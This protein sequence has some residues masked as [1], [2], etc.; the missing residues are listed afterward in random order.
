LAVNVGTAGAPVLFGGAA[1]TPSSLT[2]TNATGLPTSGITAFNADARAQVEAALVPGSNIT[3]TPSGSGATRQLT[4]ASTASGGGGGTKTLADF[5]PRDNQP[6]ATNF[7]TLYTRNS[8]GVLEFLDS[9]DRSAVFVKVIPEGANLSSGV[10]VSI[11]W[12]GDTATS[13]NVRLA[14]SFERSGTDL[15]SDSFDTAPEVTS[16]A[17]GTSGNESIAEITC[18][19]IDGLAAGERFRL[20]I[21]RRASD[22]TNDT[23]TGDMQLVAVEVQQVA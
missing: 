20:R 10:I 3:I 8:V 21:T 22:T 6:P 23:M 19:A 12:M 2:L 9:A 15:D 11:W 7:A 18:T 1:G 5:T 14:A 13:G 4:I 16:A 17:N